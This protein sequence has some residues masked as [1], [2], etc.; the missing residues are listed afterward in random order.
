MSLLKQGDKQ[1]SNEHSRRI[2][3]VI[4][5]MKQ[6]ENVIFMFETGI[7]IL[8]GFLI[9]YQV[10]NDNFE[11]IDYENFD[12]SN[13][14]IYTLDKKHINRKLRYIKEEHP[15][16]NNTAIKNKFIID[17]IRNSFSHGDVSIKLTYNAK[18]KKIM[19]HLVLVDQY[20]D[21]KSGNVY[22]NGLLVTVKDFNKVMYSD[23]FKIEK[24][25]SFVKLKKK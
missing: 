23:E 20:V 22:E 14:G 12:T 24:E 7:A 17:T 6:E 4:S 1:V 25:K 10:Q 13:F 11:A 15:Y 9:L 5:E 21:I 2:K 18:Y 3:K 16:Y 19:P 8:K